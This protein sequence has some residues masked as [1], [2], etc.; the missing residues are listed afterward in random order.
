MEMIS[1]KDPWYVRITIG[2][3]LITMLG[4]NIF[5]GRGSVPDLEI[6]PTQ[7]LPGADLLTPEPGHCKGLS[8]S[9]EF[10][11][12]VGPGDAVGLEP[13]VV[14]D[15]PFSVQ[16]DG[17]LFLVE[18]RDSLNYH[19]VLEEEWGTFSVDFDMEAS[20]K[21]HCRD[22]E[23]I[24]QLDIILEATGDQ[25]V[26]VRAE[27]FQGDYPWSGTHEFELSFPLEEGAQQK[28]EGWVLVLHLRE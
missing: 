14:G 25:M 8:G 19:D 5:S 16:E 6:T 17:G 4:C 11:V 20:I 9:L 23:D 2:F 15:I 27:G 26:E 7:I 13:I 18:G 12:L 3:T 1:K 21:G 28:G 22:N 24:G 10:Q